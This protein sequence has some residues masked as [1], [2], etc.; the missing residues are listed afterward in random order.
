[1]PHAG[2]QNSGSHAC[3]AGAL[4]AEPSSNPHIMFSVLKFITTVALMR[5]HIALGA[6]MSGSSQRPVTPSPRDPVSFSSEL[7]RHLH[8]AF[9]PT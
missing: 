1:M 8:T 3:M 5:Y 6:L 9:S 7:C 4:V 2:D